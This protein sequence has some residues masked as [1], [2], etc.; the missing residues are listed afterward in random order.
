MRK[1]EIYI[2]SFYIFNPLKL[3]I[4][5]YIFNPKIK[6]F[7]K[8]LYCKYAHLIEAF[9]DDIKNFYLL[10]HQLKTNLC[11]FYIVLPFSYNV[12][13]SNKYEYLHNQKNY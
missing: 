8:A 13:K 4:Y 5:K 12:A 10:F 7:Y 3:E 9:V 2:L 6:N 11:H 1:F